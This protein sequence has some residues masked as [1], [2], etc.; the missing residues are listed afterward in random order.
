M[1]VTMPKA[2][3][4]AALSLVFSLLVLSIAS[5]AQNQVLGEVQF[6]SK[7]RA[8]KTS[9]VWIDAQYVGYVE[10]L[11]EDK[12]VLLLPGEHEISVRQSG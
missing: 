4:K 5:Y 3:R 1:S 7:S 9:G 2:F 12:K 8:G 11:K 10:E 6:V